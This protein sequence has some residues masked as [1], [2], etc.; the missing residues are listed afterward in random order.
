MSCPPALV[1]PE[2]VLCGGRVAP[3]AAA[4]QAAFSHVPVFGSRKLLDCAPCAYVTCF[5]NDS[6]DLRYAAPTLSTFWA[7]P[8]L[9]P[10][11]P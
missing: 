2:A 10:E 8:C 5:C 6:Y 4:R 11:W 1:A 9:G 7:T 3:D